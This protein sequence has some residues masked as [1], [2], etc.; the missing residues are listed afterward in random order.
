MP[1]TKTQKSNTWSTL[2]RLV[3]PP[4]RVIERCDLCG[5]EIPPR[6][7]HVLELNQRQLQCACAACSLLFSDQGNLRFR[8]VPPRRE[9]LRDFRIS[10]MQWE[11]LLIPINLAFF[12]YRDDRDHVMA[13]YPS[14]AGAIESLLELEMWHHLATDN[15]VLKDLE[16]D[17]EALL[18]NRVGDDRD[19]YRVS[20]D[21]C[22]TLVGLIRLH[23]RGLSGG[24]EVWA[25]IEQFF[26]RLQEE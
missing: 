7:D 1:V 6:H 4:R 16:P 18:V 5:L 3:R 13:M 24:S 26:R 23:W 19:Y 17:V 25:A 12:Y 22:F 11:S 21:E 20:I 14:P 2:R 10:D 9:M 15:S 8:R